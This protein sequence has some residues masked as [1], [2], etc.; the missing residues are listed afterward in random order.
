MDMITV[1]IEPECARARG[2]MMQGTDELLRAVLGLP[3]LAHRGIAF[4]GSTAWWRARARAVA[5]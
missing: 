4:R 1:I 2:F 3:S 5:A